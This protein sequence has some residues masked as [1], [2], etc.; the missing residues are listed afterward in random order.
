MSKSTLCESCEFCS[1]GKEES[2]TLLV[3]FGTSSVISIGTLLN[4]AAG[5]EIVQSSDN[6]MSSPKKGE[7][8]RERGGVSI[9]EVALIGSELCGG[10]QSAGFMTGEDLEE[11]S[12][13]CVPESSSP[14]DTTL[15]APGEALKPGLGGD[16][17]AICNKIALRGAVTSN[18]SMECRK[19]GRNVFS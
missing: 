14:S 15:R 1:T 3:A 12:G 8:W 18:Q 5:S 4:D 13:D 19:L 11:K 7:R 16:L 9:E 10:V 2:R 6:S 17:L